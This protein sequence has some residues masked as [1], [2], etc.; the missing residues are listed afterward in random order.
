MDKHI[1]NFQRV[2]IGATLRPV[3]GL[4]VDVDYTYSTTN[5]RSHEVGGTTSGVD[6][7][8]GQLDYK[9]N[10]QTA[11]Y[12]TVR[13]GSSYNTMHTGRLFATYVYNLGNDHHF[14]AIAGMDVDLYQRGYHSS[15]RKGLLDQNQGSYPLRLATSW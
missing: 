4:T 13:M 7:W 5:S 10:F 9:E 15:E 8:S 14:K 1:S 11:T 2:Q 3:K 6:F 12:N